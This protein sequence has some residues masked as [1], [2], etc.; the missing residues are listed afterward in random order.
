MKQPEHTGKRG[1][2][3]AATTLIPLHAR[4][5]RGVR[6]SLRERFD[7]AQNKE[8]TNDGALVTAYG[9]D[10]RTAF[11]EIALA[12]RE[13]ERR[14]GSVPKHRVIAYQIRQS[15]KPGE[16][17]PEEAN[18]IG[19]ELAMRFTKGKY[20]FTVS[21]HTDRA[22]I[23]NHIL[24]SS[25]NLEV[26]HKWRNF[27]LSSFALQ[28][29]SDIICTEHRLSVIT[30]RY[31]GNRKKYEYPKR[32]S[33]RD[34]IRED[35]DLVLQTK[36]KNMK[37]VI[38][39]LQENGYEIREGKY[40][41]LRRKGKKNFIRCRSLGESYTEEA[42]AMVLSGEAAVEDKHAR[43]FD[44]MIDIEQKMREGKSA[45][46]RRW[47]NSFNLKQMAEVLLFLQEHEI[48]S[49]E[50]LDKRAEE[51]AEK[52]H[53]LSGQIK[54]LEARLHEIGD[55]KKH[56]VNY[57]K[58]RDVYT[59]YR[60]AG[61]SKQFLEEHRAEIEL[62]KAAKKAFDKLGTKKLPRVK[63]LSEE[64]GRILVQKKQAYA[65]YRKM[66][67]EMQTWQIAKKNV[68]LILDEGTGAT[69]EQEVKHR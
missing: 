59:A 56:I 64:Y 23:H 31:A 2:E 34:R 41:S 32:K 66:K 36:P 68:S 4:R 46:Y 29:L 58:T 16:V 62:H 9:C 15:F 7:Y 18:R 40:I 50:D 47:A 60:K 5:G 49:P 13:L 42:L 48:H 14:G 22:H 8:K 10:E 63:E 52:F 61:Y 12:H 33:E 37:Q 26:T 21:T 44:L 54:G 67:T 30:D 69:R 65:S 38:K 1:V 53:E 20:A 3:L 6:A 39:N 57:S 43:P 27:Y 55:L 11:L 51:S 24:F 25:V 35:I 28:R 19:Y 17:S 45:G